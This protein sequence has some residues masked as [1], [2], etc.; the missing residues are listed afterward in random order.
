MFTRKDKNWLFLLLYYKCWKA[1]QEPGNEGM[2]VWRWRWVY[3]ISSLVLKNWKNWRSSKTLTGTMFC[4]ERQVFHVRFGLGYWN[5]QRL[6]C[7][8]AVITESHV[9]SIYLVLSLQSLSCVV[10]PFFLLPPSFPSP[11]SLSPSPLRP[12]SPL[13]PPPLYPPPS[14]YRWPHP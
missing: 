7:M 4:K 10:S 8:W 1:W 11:T 9:L 12:S 6:F 5:S 3:P 14:F 13:L 2:W